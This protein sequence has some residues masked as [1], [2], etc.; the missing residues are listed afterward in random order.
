M[1][2]GYIRV[3]SKMQNLDRQEEAMKAAGIEPDNIYREKESG[4]DM[5]REVLKEL[6]GKVREG[7]SIVVVDITRLGRNTKDIVNLMD[8][9]D[10]KGI[11]I[12]SL[13]EGVDTSTPMGK[14]IITVLGAFSQMERELIRQRQKEGIEIAKRQG[15]F[16]GR[17]KSKIENFD[18]V[19]EQYMNN[20]ISMEQATKLLECSRATFYR[21]VREYEE[22]RPLNFLEL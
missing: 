1:R 12:I 6:L 22:N 5:E 11:I 16:T 9:L 18:K 14:T 13:K 7:D 15:R 21:R 3:S 2:F 4:R 19:Y 20:Q 8:E 17:P 10:K